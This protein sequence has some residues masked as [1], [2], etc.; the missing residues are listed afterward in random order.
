M[1]AG[2]L[3]FN[4]FDYEEMNSFLLADDYPLG[5]IHFHTNHFLFT[6]HNNNKAISFIEQSSHFGPRQSGAKHFLTHRAT[7]TY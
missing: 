5:K 7:I 4:E 6:E 1:E 3:N 2:E